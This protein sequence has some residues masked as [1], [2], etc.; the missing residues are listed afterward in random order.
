MQSDQGQKETGKDPVSGLCNVKVVPSRT[1]RT[2]E[3]GPFLS[4]L[5]YRTLFGLQFPFVQNNTMHPE[6]EGLSNLQKV[7]HFTKLLPAFIP[8]CSWRE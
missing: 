3:S 6:A 8:L 1:E 4:F 7:F 5:H 2:W